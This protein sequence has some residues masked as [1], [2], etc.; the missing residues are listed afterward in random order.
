MLGMSEPAGA[1]AD[2]LEAALAGDRRARDAVLTVILD[3]ERRGGTLDAV[4]RAAAG[5]SELALEMLLAAIDE[6]GIARSAIRKL[7]LDPPTID[8]IHQDVLIVVAE[9]IGTFRGESRFTTW[10]YRVARFKAIDHLRRQRDSVALSEDGLQFPTDAIRL[11]SLIAN[12]ATIRGAVDELPD[13]YRDAVVL[14]DIECL[15]YEEIATRAG[16][17]LNTAKTRVARGRA[18]V[19]AKIT[20]GGA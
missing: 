17:P 12:R 15:P 6:S 1:Q 5:G 2:E 19:A 9:K 4:A 13:H 8:D 20:S 16:I 3:P 7:V 14:R 11:S 18:L 10:L